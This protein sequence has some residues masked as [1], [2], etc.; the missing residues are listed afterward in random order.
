MASKK[1]NLL[2]VALLALSLGATAQTTGSGYDVYDSSVISNKRLPQQN[3]FWNNTYNFPAKPRN[4]WE[5]GVAAGAM[6]VSGDVTAKFPTLGFS[7]HVRKALGY[8]FSL[9]L[10]YANGTAKGQNWGIAENF[11]RNSAW[12][13]Y[14][15]PYRTKA[16]AIIPTYGFDATTIAPTLD[17]VYYNYK[18]NIQDLSLQG[19]FTLNNIRF[20]KNKT[21]LVFYG[22]AGIGAT[23]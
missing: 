17:I 16:G 9:R 21:G 20:H 15:S 18:A 2:G 6:T 3:E 4:M 13:Q 8:V 1:L 7:A 19:I 22:G 14:G 12:N 5:I 10:Q 11:G 23:A